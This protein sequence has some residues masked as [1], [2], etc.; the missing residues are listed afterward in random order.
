VVPPVLIRKV[1]V[2]KPERAVAA[3]VTGTVLVAV[4]VDEN[5]K[6]AEVKLLQRIAH[7]EG[8][9]C[10]A[11]AL[12]AVK[13]MEW[14]PATKEGVR[15]KTWITAKIPFLPSPADAVDKTPR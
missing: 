8:Q 1:T 10:N 11:V 13:Q 6:P 5:G 7:P 3:N 9:E 2:V 15:V 14:Q 12:D 4:L